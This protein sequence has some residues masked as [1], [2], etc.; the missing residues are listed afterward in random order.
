MQLG[1][2]FD[3]PTFRHGRGGFSAGF[4]HMRLQIR[5]PGM[6]LRSTALLNYLIGLCAFVL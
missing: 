2:I 6:L 4:N 3:I 1:E 5:P